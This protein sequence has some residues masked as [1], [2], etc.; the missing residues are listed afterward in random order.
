MSNDGLSELEALLT[1]SPLERAI[2]GLTQ[3]IREVGE[4]RFDDRDWERDDHRRHRHQ[5]RIR[6]QREAD[7]AQENA[8]LE[9]FISDARES[10]TPRPPA[11]VEFSEAY[12]KFVMD[13]IEQ[14]FVAS[15]TFRL[16]IVGLSKRQRMCA[17][18]AEDFPVEAGGFI[19]VVATTAGEWLCWDCVQGHAL[20]LVQG[21]RA[22]RAAQR[23]RRS[24]S[25]PSG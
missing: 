25:P 1:M 7:K 2:R 9:E 14:E 11:L 8:W 19:T 16:Y 3:L 15:R 10:T 5:E 6:A 21:R 24:R 18:C 23:K 22:Q 4:V 17:D 12:D 20:R 13:E